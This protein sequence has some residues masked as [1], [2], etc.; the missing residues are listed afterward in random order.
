MK[1]FYNVLIGLQKK[2]NRK[3][4]I[5][6]QVR[7]FVMDVFIKKTGILST[8]WNDIIDRKDKEVI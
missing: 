4:S 1:Q 3:T 5:G 8:S 2:K 7:N 6:R